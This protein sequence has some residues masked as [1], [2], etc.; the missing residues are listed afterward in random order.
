L[1]CDCRSTF[2]ITP[3]PNPLPRVRGRGDQRRPFRRR[4]GG[5]ISPRLQRRRTTRRH[6]AILLVLVSI[7]FVPYLLKIRE[8]RSSREM[9]RQPPRHPRGL[10]QYA[11]TN[12]GGLPRASSTIRRTRVTG[13]TPASM[14]AARFRQGRRGCSPTMSPL[15]FGSSCELKLVEP[16]A[17]ICPSTNDEIDPIDDASG[18][19]VPR[20]SPRELSAAPTA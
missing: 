20:R 18:R 1:N 12:N 19:S 8:N 4:R 17:F 14:A 15:L 10:S 6:Q 7:Y 3:H 5:R 16:R 2:E 11:T 9:C 13:A